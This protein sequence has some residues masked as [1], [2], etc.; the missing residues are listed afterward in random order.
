MKLSL[1][2]IVK[3]EQNNLGRCLA[4]VHDLV[5]EIIVVDTGSKDRT[6][7]IAT[8]FGAKIFHFTWQDDF[9]KARNYSLE[10]ASG[11]WIIYLDADE[12]LEPKS[13]QGLCQMNGECMA[14]GILVT[15]RSFNPK[16]ALVPYY[17]SQQVRIFRNR[18]EFR[19]ERRVHNQIVYS[20][21]RAGGDLMNSGLLVLHYGYMQPQ[22]QGGGDRCERSRKILEKATASDPQD[23]YLNAKLGFVYF[24]SGQLDLAYSY[25]RRVLL[26]LDMSQLEPDM[27]HQILAVVG[28]I[29]LTHQ[30]YQL[31]L[32]CSQ[33]AIQLNSQAAL[34]QYS[35]KIQAM[36]LMGLGQ[37]KATQGF[38]FLEGAPLSGGSNRMMTAALPLLNQSLEYLHQSVALFKTMILSPDLSS[39]AKVEIEKYLQESQKLA[40]DI[41][42]N[43]F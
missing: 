24:E 20:I 4:S 18:P 5:E 30:E 32:Q 28:S 42:R 6:V 34:S 36:A 23:A 1:C 15:V 12:E 13:R 10:Q 14:Q 26:E 11:E 16:D 41:T 43:L 3:N 35:L 27:I 17:D 40:Q 9:S 37:Q 25:L 21:K 2:M 8:G 39:P 22:V 38:H 31:A 33:A 29:A 7:E 19:F